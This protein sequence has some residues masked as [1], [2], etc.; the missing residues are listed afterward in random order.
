MLHIHLKLE[1]LN[2]TLALSAPKFTPP[3]LLN[4]NDTIKFSGLRNILLPLYTNWSLCQANFISKISPNFLSTHHFSYHYDNLDYRLLQCIQTPYK[5]MA[6]NHSS[7]PRPPITTQH[8]I[9]QVLENSPLLKYTMFF[10]EAF[11]FSPCFTLCLE[12]PFDLPLVKIMS[13][14]GHGRWSQ[15]WVDAT[16]ALNS[17]CDIAHTDLF[18]AS[19]SLPV[20]WEQT[21]ILYRI[22]FLTF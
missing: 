4:L 9:L 20:K 17:A 12:C 2:W 14:L 5:L 19:V 13:R 10:Q 7:S 22:C 15:S 11:F 18:Y 16:I 1:Y 8:L 3:L 21:Y 6:T